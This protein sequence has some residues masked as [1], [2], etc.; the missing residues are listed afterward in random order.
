ML[1]HPDIATMC[2]ALGMHSS[3]S[4]SYCYPTARLENQAKPEFAGIHYLGWKDA[5]CIKLFNHHFGWSDASS[6]VSI[7][8]STA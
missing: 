4:E 7:G 6:T 2:N 5:A 3:E 8:I 1:T